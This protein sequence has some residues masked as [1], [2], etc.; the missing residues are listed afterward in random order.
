LKFITENE[1]VRMIKEGKFEEVI[2]KRVGTIRSDFESKFTELNS[3]LTSEQ[4]KAQK[5]EGLYQRKTLEDALRSAAV[6]SKV[7]PEAVEDVVKNGLDVF[8]LGE[9]L[10]SVEAR[11]SKGKLRKTEDDKI[12]TT[13]LW[14]EGLKKSKPHYW[15]QSESANFDN[16]DTSDDIEKA[17][18]RAADSGNTTEYRRLKSLLAKAR[19]GK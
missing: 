9:D 2:E 17:M 14:V 3:T 12:L 1:D 16:T 7:R 19:G 15:P 10:Q 11:D 4:Q 13:N 5:F 18:N 6:M 8:S